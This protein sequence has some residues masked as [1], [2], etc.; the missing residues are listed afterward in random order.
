MEFLKRC[1][2]EISLDSIRYNA[3]Q[4]KKFLGP[5]TELLCVVKANCYGHSDKIIV[6]FL[7]KELGVSWFA[8]ANLTEAV[9]LREEGIKGNIL[10]LGMTPC[11]YADE[12][13]RY[14]IIQACTELSYAQALCRCETSGRV[15]LHC[16]ID[17]GMTRIG[18]TGTPEENAEQL[19]E[20]SKLEGVKLEG[21]FTH[22]ACADTPDE[23]SCA[24]TAMQTGRIKETARLAREKGVELSQVHFLNSAGG[25]HHYDSESTLARL[26]II[27]YGLYPDADTPLPFVPEPVMTFVGMISQVKTI[28]PGTSV[29][30]GRTFTAQKEMKLATVCVGY[31]DGY[32]RA[33]SNKGEVLINGHRCRITGRVCMDQFMCDVTD[34]GE[35][36]PGDDAVLIGRQGSEQITADDIAKLTGTIGYEIVCGISQRVPRVCASQTF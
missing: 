2:A 29:S 26:G 34:A 21:I 24:Y 7:E 13:V 35:V 22:Y 12:L 10:I 8:V 30:Y 17:T 4:Y 11:E 14:D 23:E 18:L 36:K 33:L 28:M 32:P 20:I 16:A 31:A 1:R 25:I 27:L 5:K 6:P 15:R 3:Q 9:R 19:L